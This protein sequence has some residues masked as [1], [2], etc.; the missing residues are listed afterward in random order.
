MKKSDLKTGMIVTTRNGKELTVFLSSCSHY[1]N[2]QSV[3]VN[4][5][6]KNWFELDG[7]ISEDLNGIG[8]YNND[9]DITETT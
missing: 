3:L 9:Y 8:F 2:N 5:E 1:A 7:S 6:T 4:A